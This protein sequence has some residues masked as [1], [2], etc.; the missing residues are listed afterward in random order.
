M[1]KQDLI[2]RLIRFGVYRTDKRHLYELSEKELAILI[3]TS[4]IKRLKDIKVCPFLDLC[5]CITRNQCKELEKESGIQTVRKL[6]DVSVQD[7]NVVVRCSKCDNAIR[8]LLSGSNQIK[9]K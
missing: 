1:Y 2:N 4:I 5:S 8:F 3:V 9:G 7:N 6:F